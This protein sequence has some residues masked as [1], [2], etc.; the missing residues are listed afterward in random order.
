M[1]FPHS[2][3]LI[4]ALIRPWYWEAVKAGLVPKVL[5]YMGRPLWS[6]LTA[7]LRLSSAV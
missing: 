1:G 4:F 6:K 5:K 3:L 2:E 7:D